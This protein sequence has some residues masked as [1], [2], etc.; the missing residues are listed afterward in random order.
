MLSRNNNWLTRS[1]QPT[2]KGVES[3]Q[4]LLHWLNLLKATAADDGDRTFI[5]SLIDQINLLKKKS[6]ETD[7]QMK[8]LKDG[9]SEAFVSGIGGFLDSLT[10][11]T[12]TLAQSFKNMVTSILS[13]ISRLVSR[14]IA[15]KIVFGIIGKAEGGQA[16]NQTQSQGRAAGGLG[17]PPH[18]QLKGGIPG[19]DSIHIAAMPEEYFVKVPAVRYYG[20]EFMDAINN[21]QLPRVNARNFRGMAIGGGAMEPATAT[22]RPSARQDVHHHISVD[23]D[24]LLRVLRGRPGREAT[25]GHIQKNPRFVSGAVNQGRK[26]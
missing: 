5:Q 17:R 9:I 24:G 12:V 20:T 16:G 6:V 10:D 23:D 1:P 18:G 4:E 3:S 11:K 25:L 8:R 2:G 7:D 26:R 15:E 14:L 19:T 22:A 13:D 21:M